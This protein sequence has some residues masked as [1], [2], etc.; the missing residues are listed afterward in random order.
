V[1]GLT[2]PTH[3]MGQ[4][5]DM[6][7]VTGYGANKGE[8]HTS[9]TDPPTTGGPDIVV[10]V[11][12]PTAVFSLNQRV[13]PD[14]ACSDE[15][16]IDR[17]A[18]AVLVAGD[19]DTSSPGEHT[20]TVTAED[21]AGNVS[22]KS[23]TYVVRYTFQGFKSPVD[24][25]PTL[26]VAKLGSTIPIKWSLLDVA[27]RYVSDLNSV[28]SV[29][30]EKIRCPSAATDAIEETTNLGI[31]ALKYDATKNQF[32]YTWQ[33]VKSWGAGCRRVHVAFADGTVRSADFQ[34]R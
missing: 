34:L 13:T 1:N 19:L 33:T 27:G 2:T 11:P 31:V 12:R 4:A 6:H 32:V 10:E 3:I 30:S 16:A 17:C 26:N 23:V 29:T 22:T 28:T 21:L 14:F 20:F 15:G 7:G 25:Q 18:G 8:N 24:N 5:M 9:F